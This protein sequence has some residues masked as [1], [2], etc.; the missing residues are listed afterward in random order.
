MWAPGTCLIVLVPPHSLL[1][2]SWKGSRGQGSLLCLQLFI[3]L[4]FLYL[5]ELLDGVLE[6]DD[7]EDEDDEVSRR[8]LTPHE[9]L[10][11]DY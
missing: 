5:E 11:P 1:C 3:R 2:S 6:S 10:G 4:F 8:L 7:D 9:K